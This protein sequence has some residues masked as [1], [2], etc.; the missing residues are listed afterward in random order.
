MRYHS[1]VL[2]E[3]E[4]T[5]LQVIATTADNEVMA[6]AHG[7]LPIAGM[8]FHPESILTPYGLPMLKNWFEGIRS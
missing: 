3:V 2:T 4:K 8:Q 7:T 1:L 6:V 5:G